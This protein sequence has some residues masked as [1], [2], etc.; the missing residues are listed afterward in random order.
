MIDWQECV[1]S[2]KEFLASARTVILDKRMMQGERGS[3]D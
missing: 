2:L 3:K 1:Y